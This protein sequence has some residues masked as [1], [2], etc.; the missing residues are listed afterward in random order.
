MKKIIAILIISG[1]FLLLPTSGAYQLWDIREAELTGITQQSGCLNHLMLRE[2]DTTTWEIIGDN[3]GRLAWAGDES[4]AFSCGDFLFNAVIRYGE[5][6]NEDM[7]YSLIYYPDINEIEIEVTYGSAH[8][9][10]TMIIDTYYPDGTFSG[11]GYCHNPYLTWTVSGTF[12]HFT[13]K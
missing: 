6:M 3:W 8:Y 7:P 9:I 11:T 5:D 13:I 10:H 2:K 12:E 4:Y 1:L